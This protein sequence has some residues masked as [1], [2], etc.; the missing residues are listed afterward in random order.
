MFTDCKKSLNILQCRWTFSQSVPWCLQLRKARGAVCSVKELKRI[1][2]SGLIQRPVSASLQTRNK[3]FS[4]AS[5]SVSRLFMN[6]NWFHC[7][8]TLY[9]SSLN[10]GFQF[11]FQSKSLQKCLF[12][13]NVLWDFLVNRLM[14]FLRFF[15]LFCFFFV[16][17]FL[18]NIEYRAFFNAK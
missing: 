5:L 13:G 15:F 11:Y 17:V 6:I 8:T 4:T 16:F 2:T 14:S 18:W 7:D 1:W 3:S 10:K 12:F 9:W